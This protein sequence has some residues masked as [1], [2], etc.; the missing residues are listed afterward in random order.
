[1]NLLPM[2]LHTPPA[3]GVAVTQWYT[4]P[5][6]SNDLHVIWD[7]IIEDELGWAVDEDSSGLLHTVNVAGELSCVKGEK[8][9]RCHKCDR[10]RQW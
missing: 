4:Y 7:H 2:V 5:T 9:N 1:M 6:A 10:P 8:L 3:C